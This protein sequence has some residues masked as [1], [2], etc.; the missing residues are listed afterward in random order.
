MRTLRKLTETEKTYWGSG[1]YGI[2]EKGNVLFQ[3][4][5]SGC[6]TWLN[7]GR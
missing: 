2:V 7:S 4:T 3:G 6:L 5:Y 1:D